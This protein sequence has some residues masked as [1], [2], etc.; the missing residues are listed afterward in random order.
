MDQTHE[1][2]SDLITNISL[3]TKSSKDDVNFRQRIHS[4][5]VV[6]WDL[7]F[8]QNVFNFCKTA[9]QFFDSLF[10]I[11]RLTILIKKLS[12]SWTRKNFLTKTTSSYI[13]D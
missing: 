5:S 2:P 7:P 12:L 4:V 6:A 10:G 3:N 1:K 9:H 13:S 8:D 11:S